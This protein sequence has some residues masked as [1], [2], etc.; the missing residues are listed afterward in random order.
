MAVRMTSA[1]KR[2]PSLRT[3]QPSLLDAAALGGQ[4]QQLRRP[5]AVDILLREEAREVL[6]QNLIG[7]VAL[8]AL[9]AGVPGHDVA[10][11]VEQIDGVVADAL[12]DGA[13]L[14]VVAAQGLQRR[15][16]LGYVAHEAQHHGAEGRLG[17]LQ[18]DVDGKLG[19]ILAQGEQIHGRAHLARAR[20]GGVVLA[21]AGMAAA[22]ALRNEV[23][24]RQADQLSRR[25]AEQL[26]AARVCGTD[27]A[28]GVGDE[29]RVGRE[30]EQALGRE[31]GEFGRDHFPRSWLSHRLPT[32]FEGRHWPISNPIE[33]LVL[34]SIAL[35]SIGC[36]PA[37]TSQE[38]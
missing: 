27:H 32:G 22:E 26:R 38:G 9:A 33:G 29:D 1:Q 36:K 28:L 31:L 19:A 4:A 35:R 7:G 15:A 12:D 30:I 8:D 34:Q 37:G 21:M 20:M 5:A 13:Q 24:D 6:A 14:L 16:L 23:L 18:H 10:V 2:E 25:V 11:A 3:R 17:R